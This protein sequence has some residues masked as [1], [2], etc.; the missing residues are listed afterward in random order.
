MSEIVQ[1]GADAAAAAAKTAVD[2]SLSA[3]A[4]GGFSFSLKI[5]NPWLAAGIA[6]GSFYLANKVLTERA[7]KRALERQSTEADD[8]PDPEVIETGAGSILVQLVCHTRES[9]LSFTDDLESK[10]VKYRLEEELS[11]VGFCE[12]IRLTVENQDEFDCIR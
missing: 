6:I 5:D 11:R 2:V 1:S 3:G 10:K 7:L 4:F 8:R 12:E 9:F